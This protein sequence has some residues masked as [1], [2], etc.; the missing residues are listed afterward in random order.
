VYVIEI[1]AMKVEKRQ[2]VYKNNDALPIVG[3]D[4]NLMLIGLHG[5][6]LFIF[7]RMAK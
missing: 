1:I 3:E 4:H 7:F 2:L 5:R 6:H